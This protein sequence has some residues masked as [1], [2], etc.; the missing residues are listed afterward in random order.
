M[1]EN[2]IIPTQQEP[3]VEEERIARVPMR[4]WMARISTLVTGLVGYGASTGRPTSD[5]WIGR[6]YFNTTTGQTEW[7]NGLTWVTWTGGV[8]GSGYPEALGYAGL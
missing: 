1:S 5:L 6:P 3:L 4:Q 7:W 8:G 2:I